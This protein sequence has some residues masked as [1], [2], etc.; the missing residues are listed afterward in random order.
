[1][2]C[3]FGS[4]CKDTNIFGSQCVIKNVGKLMARDKKWHTFTNWLP[5]AL[6][7]S[8]WLWLVPRGLVGSQR[9]WLSP[10]SIGWKNP[11]FLSMIYCC[12]MYLYYLNKKD[13]KLQER[14]KKQRSWCLADSELSDD[15]SLTVALLHSHYASHKHEQ[16]DTKLL[17]AWIDIEGPRRYNWILGKVFWEIFPKYGWPTWITVKTNNRCFPVYMYSL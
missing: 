4:Q 2:K 14:K 7:G 11:L 12:Y 1:M 16:M 3:W 9:P 17:L 5:G 13:L 10:R 8:H 15:R 6:V